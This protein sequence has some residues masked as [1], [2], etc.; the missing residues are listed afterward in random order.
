D[1]VMERGAEDTAGEDPAA[2]DVSRPARPPTSGSDAERWAAMIGERVRAL[3]SRASVDPPL[4]VDTDLRPEGR[5][6]PLVRTLDSY[7]AY[8]RKWAQPWEIQALLRA[9]VVAGDRGLGER[10][11]HMIDEV[12]YPA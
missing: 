1:P 8:Y 11:L 9:T 7:A 5:S 3:L 6:G 4:E 12:R 10:F 2:E